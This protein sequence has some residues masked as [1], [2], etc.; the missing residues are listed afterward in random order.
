MKDV[1]QRSPIDPKG[2]IH[3]LHPTSFWGT[4]ITLAL[5]GVIFFFLKDGSAPSDSSPSTI[6][7][8]LS[9]PAFLLNP[10]PPMAGGPRGYR[11][12]GSQASSGNMYPS[13]TEAVTEREP[14]REQLGHEEGKSPISGAVTGDWPGVG[15][16]LTT[17]IY[18]R[19]GQWYMHENTHV[20]NAGV[21]RTGDRHLQHQE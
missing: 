20:H 18:T 1:K 19:T 17:P 12:G 11:N 4:L 6:L 14:G 21:N 5:G 7:S 15:S 13:D 16:M 8:L 10:P 2:H 9:L 3:T